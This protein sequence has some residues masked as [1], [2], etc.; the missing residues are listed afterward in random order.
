MSES[1]TRR[2]IQIGLTALPIALSL[3]A[4]ADDHEIRIGR[5]Q[6]VTVDAPLQEIEAKPTLQPMKI[7]EDVTTRGEALQ[8]ILQDH[9][10]RL[11][12][13]STRLLVAADVL[14][15]ALLP[16]ERQ[17]TG[18]PLRLAL[19]SLLGNRMQVIVDSGTQ[20]VL[21]ST[22]PQADDASGKRDV[23]E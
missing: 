1:R 19:R 7:P 22:N 12:T 15:A 11:H 21:V 14:A 5:Y 2:R 13:D 16:E 8:W 10:Y 18:E 17:R 4:N 9:G 6:T 3:S 20:Q 23:G